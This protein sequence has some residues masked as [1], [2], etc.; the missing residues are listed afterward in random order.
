[1][2]HQSV[3]RHSYPFCW[4]SDTPLIYKAVPSWFVAVEKVKD[5]LVANNKLSRWVPD[6]VQEKRFHNWLQD[7]RDWAISRNRFW[8]TPI[9]IW[10]STDGEEIVVIGSIA[11]LEKLSGAKGIKDLHRES[12]D[13]I[14]IPSSKGKGTLR[15]ID[16]VFDCWF[17][18][19]SMPYAQVHYPFENKERF[20]KSFPADFIAEGID[21]VK[22]KKKKILIDLFI[23]YYL[24]F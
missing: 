20:E 18:S 23:Y 24:L 9:P 16:E 3:F 11:E 15:R 4:R 17:E 14:T 7:A 22:K 10:A 6:W 13:H 12:I 5:K 21:Q 2:I 1:M 19:G 8:G